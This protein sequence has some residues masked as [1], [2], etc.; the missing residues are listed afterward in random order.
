MRPI[1]FTKGLLTGTILGATMS[2]I[3]NPAEGKDRKMVK[4]KTNRFIKTIGNA[5]EDIVDMRR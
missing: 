3:F 2:M 1:G 4:K 5:I